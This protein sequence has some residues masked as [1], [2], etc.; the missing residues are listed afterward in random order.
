MHTAFCFSDA[1]LAYLN[2]KETIRCN[3][4]KIYT[5]FPKACNLVMMGSRLPS[6]GN[7]GITDP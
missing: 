1:S 5:H 2:V 3:R 6:L 4:P 7:I